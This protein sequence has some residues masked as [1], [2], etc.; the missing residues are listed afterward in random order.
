MEYEKLLMK[1]ENVFV[2]E[3]DMFDNLKGLYYDSSI[4]INKKLT[5]NAERACVLAEELGHHYTS[6]GNILDTNNKNNRKQEQLARNWGYTQLVTMEGLIAAY[7]NCCQNLFEVAEY[8]GITE[9]YLKEALSYYTG[10]YGA[11][12]TYKPYIICFEPLSFSKK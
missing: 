9:E 12:Y 10:K 2:K 7:E 3:I 6:C 11:F 8:L 4:S 1:H 5:T